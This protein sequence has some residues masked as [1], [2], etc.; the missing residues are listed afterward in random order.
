MTNKVAEVKKMENGKLAV[1]WEGKRKFNIVQDD[2]I[3]IYLVYLLTRDEKTVMK[4][5]NSR[6]R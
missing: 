3:A 6:C 2:E 1:R 5:Q 4:N